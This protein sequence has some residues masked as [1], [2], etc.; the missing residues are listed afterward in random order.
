MALTIDYQ[1]VLDAADLMRRA[2]K[3]LA[4]EMRRAVTREVNPWLK[5]A[6][7][8]QATDAQSRLIAGTARVRSGNNPAVVVGSAKKFSGGASTAELARVYEFGGWQEYRRGYARKGRKGGGRHK[9]VRHT[10]RQ[11]PRQDRQGRFVYPAVADAA[12]M[13]VGA[14]VGVIV[15]LWSEVSDGG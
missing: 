8:R 6:I 15:D 9:V 13:L 10:Q 7:R 4:K 3:D 14:W 11:I 1:P 2:D 5:S 12:P